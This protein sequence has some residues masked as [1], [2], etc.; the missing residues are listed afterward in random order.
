M[1]WDEIRQIE[2]EIYEKAQKLERLRREAMP[3]E[4]PDYTFQTLTGPVSLSEMFGEKGKMIVVH[5]M[6][7]G[8][9]WCT[10]WADGING[11]LSHLESEFSVVLVSK[12]SPEVQRRFAMSRQWRFRMASHGGGKYI[13]E[14]SVVGGDSNSP[15]IVC[16]ERKDHKIYR[17]NASGFGPGDLFNPLFHIVTLGGIGFEEFTPQFFYWRQPEKMDDGGANLA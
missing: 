9:R 5:N 6:G 8:C 12:D 4:V 10:S 15:G 3:I 1:S 13:S 14:Q 11:V 7:Q 2:T 16:Y 17:K